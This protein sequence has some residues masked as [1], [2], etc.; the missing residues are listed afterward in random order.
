MKGRKPKPTAIHKQNGNPSK[1]DLDE[2]DQN[3]PKPPAPEKIPRP[4]KFFDKVAKKE[5]RRCIKV[6]IAMGVYTQADLAIFQGYC[7]AYSQMIHCG[8]FLLELDGKLPVYKTP[9]GALIQMP[10]VSMFNKS[11]EKVKAACAELGFTPSARGRMN[12]PGTPENGKSVNPDPK[13]MESLISRQT[14][15][16]KKLK[17]IKEKRKK[18]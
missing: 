18:K 8:Q 1:K 15:K 10:Q 12:I 4:P 2:R 5:W 13:G 3:E 7:I 16:P 6:L 14:N 9:G 11:F 17:K